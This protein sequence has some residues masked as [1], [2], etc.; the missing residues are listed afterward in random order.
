MKALF[1]RGSNQAGNF[2]RLDSLEFYSTQIWVPAS[3][4]HTDNH[5][6]ESLS[7]VVFDTV[8]TPCSL[9][10][11][12][13]GSERL[14][15]CC[16]VWRWNWATGSKLRRSGFLYVE[17]LS[18]SVFWTHVGNVKIDSTLTSVQIYECTRLKWETTFYFLY[19]QYKPN[20]ITE[21]KVHV[22]SPKWKQ[23]LRIRFEIVKKK[24][25]K[26]KPYILRFEVK[27]KTSTCSNSKPPGD[28]YNLNV[29]PSGISIS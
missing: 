18:M 11:D 2:F 17:E 29:N 14:H 13:D 3:V 21:K 28:E 24:K 27:L 12:N 16:E 8:T 7:V 25:K 4:S 20:H 23:Q 5:N 19:I 1:F 6:T 9:N 10:T 26:D 15:S 22:F